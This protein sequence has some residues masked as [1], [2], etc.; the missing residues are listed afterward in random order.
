MGRIGQKEEA[1]IKFDRDTDLAGYCENFKRGL[2]NKNQ[3]R[4]QQQYNLKSLYTAQGELTCWTDSC[5]KIVLPAFH[6]GFVRMLLVVILSM[7]PCRPSRGGERC[8]LR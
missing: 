5:P 4:D 1:R 2:D 8:A 7:V 3:P 6:H